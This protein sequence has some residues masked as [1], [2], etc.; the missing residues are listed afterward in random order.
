M[1]IIKKK[2]IISWYRFGDPTLNYDWIKKLTEINIIK[3][4]KLTDD[5]IKI[6]IDNKHRIFLHIVITGM[7][8]TPFEPNIPTVKETFYSI[9]KLI[10]FGF[11]QK[12]IL[13]CVENIIPNQN[14]LKALELLLR[15][16]TEFRQ[17]RLRF[18]RFNVLKF[19]Q[20]NG[21]FQIKNDNINKRPQVKTLQ[22]FLF[23]TPSFF[24]DYFN[25]IQKYQGIISVD[26]GE[27]AII[28]TRELLAFGYRNEWIDEN[29]LR[30]KL[31]EYENGNKYKPILNIISNKR[32][33][34]CL[35]KCLLCTGF[36]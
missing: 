9:K 33:I 32:N 30:T 1:D 10:D 16:F 8:K 14:G 3:T 11:P 13:V 18:I 7:G 28:G 22:Q 21:V 23:T 34:R 6:C 29:G 24:K 2:P 19:T 20:D 4:K 25:L 36:N 17:L 31:I 5:F 27:E 35:N 15:V 26:K 12:Q